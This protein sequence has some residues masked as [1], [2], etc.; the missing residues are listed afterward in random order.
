MVTTSNLRLQVEFSII[1]L[2]NIDILYVIFQVELS[3]SYNNSM[4]S[5]TR[6]LYSEGSLANRI[7]LELNLLKETSLLCSVFDS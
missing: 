4:S 2:I 3:S 1:S 5:P 7:F 6:K